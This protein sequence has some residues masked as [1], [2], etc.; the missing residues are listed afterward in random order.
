[1][2][3]PAPATPAWSKPPQKLLL[4]VL[5][6]GLLTCL[7]AVIGCAWHPEWE[8]HLWISL[9]FF[10]PLAAQAVGLWWLRESATSAFWWLNFW[11]T[12][13]CQSVYCWLWAA[14]SD[15][16]FAGWGWSLT[17]LVS[18]M[19]VLGFV[20]TMTFAVMRVSPVK[21]SVGRRVGSPQTG[22]QAQ[23][24]A[25]TQSGA[26]KQ[27][28]EEQ[29]SGRWE[30]FST[31]LSAGVAAHPFWSI[32]F[33]MSLFL[34]VSYLFGFALAFHD[35]QARAEDAEKPALYMVKHESVDDKYVKKSASEQ[36]G[37]GTSENEGGA[38]RTPDQSPDP[39]AD[40]TAAAGPQ[41]E[42]RFHFEEVRANVHQDKHGCNR[43]IL[44]DIV[45]S[46]TEKVDE[47]RR[48][49]VT[50]LGHTDSEPVPVRV[51]ESST[52][53]YLLSSYLSNYELSQA[54]A[55]NVQYEVL[56]RLRDKPRDLE[57]IQWVIYPTADEPL[58]QVNHGVL[59]SVATGTQL[60]RYRQDEKRYM[61]EIN[62]R[63]PPVEKRVVIAT[64]ETIQERPVVLGP[65][66]L[67]GITEAQGEQLGELQNIKRWQ[68]RYAED[69]KPKEL[70]LMDYVYFSIYTITTTGYGDI[71]P[72]T[73]YAK[74]VTSVANLFEVIFLVVFFNAILS[75]KGS[76]ESSTEPKQRAAAT[77]QSDRASDRREQAGGRV[78][79]IGDAQ[80]VRQQS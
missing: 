61:K 26:P 50:L 45:K 70:R 31:A 43:C 8:S 37:Q 3:H 21:M 73:A 42:F 55:Q 19:V 41:K 9:L 38:Q 4:A 64:I 33:F 30:E 39:I 51:G 10:T 80:K 72:N 62:D 53:R 79:N 56:Q 28:V 12:L 67:R 35:R 60:D 52:T 29:P 44:E 2:S 40:A 46:L 49:R 32:T 66:Q 11:A 63:L 14:Y 76:G 6:F 54:R 27:D 16:S 36:Y 34:G 1:M 65:D 57:N 78:A 22:A 7:P 20:I 77:P 68:E 25:P 15:P 74:F 17:A 48:V 24:A 23:Q 5:A 59:A 75:L 58:V 13:C 69:N 71:V 18:T 47:G